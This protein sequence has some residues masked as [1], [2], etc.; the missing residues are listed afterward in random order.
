LRP[1]LE[2]GDGAH[3]AGRACSIDTAL[4]RADFPLASLLIYVM[5]MA[6]VAIPL[7]LY[8]EYLLKLCGEPAAPAD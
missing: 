5:G 2:G 6:F 3:R 4:A 1:R 8:H 7:L